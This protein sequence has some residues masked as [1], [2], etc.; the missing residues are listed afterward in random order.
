M[1]KVQGCEEPELVF[2]IYGALAGI[3]PE[4]Y[5]VYEHP[6]FLHFHLI[7]IYRNVKPR[8]DCDRERVLSSSNFYLVE[9]GHFPVG[10]MY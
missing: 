2:E 7:Y 9:H 3:D 10:I 8:D 1:F 5:S 4:V 6:C